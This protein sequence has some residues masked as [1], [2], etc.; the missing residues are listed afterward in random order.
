M[1]ARLRQFTEVLWCAVYVNLQR[2]YD[3][4]FPSF[5]RHFTEPRLCPITDILK[6]PV[7]TVLQTLVESRFH[8]SKGGHFFDLTYIEKNSRRKK[9]R[10]EEGKKRNRMAHQ[11]SLIVRNKILRI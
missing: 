6:S 4:P 10:K 3:A 7:H 9:E 5:Y 8:R 1:M 11:R 2:F